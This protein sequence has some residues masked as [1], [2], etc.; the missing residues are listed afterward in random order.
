MQCLYSL[1]IFINVSA[2]EAVSYLTSL[3]LV[4]RQL[5]RKIFRQRLEVGDREA[6]VEQRRVSQL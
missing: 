6:D 1:D 4:H 5:G 2:R 3:V